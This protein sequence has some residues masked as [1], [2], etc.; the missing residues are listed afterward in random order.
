MDYVGQ[1]AVVLR[2][3]AIR[4]HLLGVVADLEL[5][6]CWIAAGF[7]RNAVWDALHGRSESPISGDVDVIWFDQ[8]CSDP[9]RDRAI[10][11]AL[12]A[13]EPSIDWS[14]KNQARMHVRNCD[15]PYLCATEA[16]RHWP[17]TATA[18]AARRI[19]SDGCEIASPLG[20]DDLFHLVI[21]PTTKFDVQKRSIFEERIQKK[22]WFE[23]WP[24]L[25]RGV[26]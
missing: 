16:M 17:E 1:V 18:V 21:R 3:D 11:E 2:A 8:S 15:A 4:W 20:L 24:M 25:H 10:E 14:V 12:R 23:N 6:D 22:A 7:V 9:A 13:T 26:T 19:G 5:P